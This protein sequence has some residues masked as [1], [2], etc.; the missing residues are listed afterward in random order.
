MVR[1]AAGRDDQQT[2]NKPAASWRDEDNALAL[3][4]RSASRKRRLETYLAMPAAELQGP[5]DTFSSFCSERARFRP[6]YHQAG[7]SGIWRKNF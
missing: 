2:D 1:Y 3:A 5:T 4:K 7:R 6:G